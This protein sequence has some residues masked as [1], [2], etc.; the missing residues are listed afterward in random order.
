MRRVYSVQR[1]NHTTNSNCDRLV[2]NLGPRRRLDVCRT[3][4]GE[5]VC[6]NSRVPGMRLWSREPQI[7]R[8]RKCIRDTEIFRD[9]RHPC[10]RVANNST[11]GGFNGLASFE[12]WRRWR[13]NRYTGKQQR[14]GSESNHCE[15]IERICCS[16]LRWI[17]TILIPPRSDR[18]PFTNHLQNMNL[19]ASQ[20]ELIDGVR[21]TSSRERDLFRVICY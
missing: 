3:V 18:V 7:A 19:D 20:S 9:T 8:R 6:G 16:F 13:G 12:S 4:R 14:S 10:R 11:A 15:L 21:W 2:R 1:G 5:L 17:S